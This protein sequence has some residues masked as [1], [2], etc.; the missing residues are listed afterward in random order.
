[1]KCPRLAW[2]HPQGSA[3]V[4][5]LIVFAGACGR[6]PQVVGATVA[7]RVVVRVDAS[8]ARDTTDTT[9]TTAPQDSAGSYTGHDARG[10]PRYDAR[11]FSADERD[12]LRRIFGVDDPAL[13][14]V[15]DSTDSGILKYDTE[16]KRCARCYVNS[17]RIGFI[18]LRRPGE[19]WRAL[20]QRVQAMHA[21][22]FPA[23]AHI[24][25]ISTDRLEPAIRADVRTL[26]ADAASAG[27]RIRVAATYRSPER[28]AF[29]MAMGHGR[30]HT[31]T[32]MHSYG[33]A[34]DILVDDGNP[35]RTRTRA[36]WI[37][38]RHWVIAYRH[39]EFR[40]LG[41][42]DKTWDWAH[43]EVPDAGIGFTTIDEAI[44]R[45]RE[46]LARASNVACEFE[47]HLSPDRSFSDPVPPLL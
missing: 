16:R 30:T 25:D 9:L 43:I 34:I 38:F 21:S 23:W 1:M 31:L 3:L 32:S 5:L 24:E 15:S 45:A 27:F 36:D 28:E 14:Y 8:A 37:R 6:A 13:L 46:C 40:V 29:L 33:R 47:P 7:Q 35:A 39:G 22:D 20:E 4:A 12:A 26:L 2:G 11:A 42:V 10:I 17:Y 41:A 19:S 18:S 44:A